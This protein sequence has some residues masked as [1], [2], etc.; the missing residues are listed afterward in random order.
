M[1]RKFSPK[2]KKIISHSRDEAVRLHN[3]YIGTEHLLLGII[4]DKDSLALKVL[5]SLDVDI[6]QLKYKIEDQ[7][8]S[9]RSDNTGLNVGNIPLNKHAEKVLKVTFL[10]A[11]LYKNEEISPEHLMLSIL[12]HNENIA[13][14]ILRKFDV[15]YEAY[16][17][18]LEFV[19]QEDENGYSDFYSSAAPGDSDVPMD[20][21][22]NF[23]SG[24]KPKKGKSR[25]RTP[26]LDNFGRDISKLAEEDKLDPIIG[27]EKEIERV[28]QILSR[29]KKN[30]PI[31]IGEPGVGKTAIAE[32]LALKI[33]EKKVS[34]NLFG[35]RVV[36]LDLAAL[37]A[38][39]KYRGEFEERFKGVLKK[40]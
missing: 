4:E 17:V 14:K 35:K 27:R 9:R 40:E 36:M 6:D 38:G 39:T 24:Q 22:D 28:S 34:R 37:V 11:K 21:D 10:E 23:G 2:V 26:V 20:D 3:D 32:G 1:N 30:N 16:K 31:L 18:E 7:T 5:D 29:R 15:D 19:I 13:S 12:K 8:G 25:S 33:K